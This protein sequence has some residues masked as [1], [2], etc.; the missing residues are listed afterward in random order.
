MRSPSKS[1]TTSTATISRKWIDALFAKFTL[2]WPREWADK[3]AASGNLEAMANEWAEGLAGLTGEQIK[4]GIVHCRA[5]LKWSPTIAEFRE[6]ATL[7]DTPEQRAMRTRLADADAERKA[8]PSKTWAESRA[9]GQR[10]AREMLARLRQ[11]MAEHERIAV[12]APAAEI[13]P[14]T[15]TPEQIARIETAKRA[16]A[17]ALSR[18]QAQRE[19]A[20]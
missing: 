12:S 3:V 14:E 8:L 7:G 10:Q 5:N 19:G 15:V 2:L 18:M 1:G 16:A 17:E 20:A 9:D 11:G 4:A 6:A 13:E